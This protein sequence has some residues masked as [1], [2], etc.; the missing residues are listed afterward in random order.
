M[1]NKKFISVVCIILAVIFAATL[2]LG[3]ISSAWAVSQSDIDALKNKQAA[4][5]Q[6][7]TAIQTQIENAKGQVRDAEAQ[8]AELDKKNQLAQQEIDNINEQIALY[9][10][11]IAE[12]AEELKKA[13][14]AEDKQREALEK[15]MR[16]M[17][18]TP[19][20]T[21]VAILFQSSDFSDLLS[22]INDI[23]AIM[24][25]DK[26]LEDKY[27]AA[28]KEVETVKNEYEQT[29]NAQKQTKVELD[30][31]KAD[32][33]A[34]IAQANQV[35]ADLESNI[36]AYKQQ[37]EAEEAREAAIRSQID[38]QVAEFEAQQKA[39]AQ[40]GTGT[41]TNGTGQFTWPVPASRTISSSFGYRVHPIFGTTKYHSGID[42]SASSGS[43]IVAADSGTV[44]TA[45]YSSSYGNYVVIGHGN[46]T[47]TLYA[48]MSKLGCSAG[49]TVT[50]GSTIG[51]V[52]ST[53]WSTGP[54]CHF[55]IRINGSLVNP[56][57]YF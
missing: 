18:E 12:K 2:I 56:A 16:A 52:G 28:R 35:I 9:D 33:E 7:K 34:Q 47:S 32:L 55:E 50:K 38:K 43:T 57:S 54:H 42:I 48:H 21:Y 36:E 24:T 13:Q 14:A 20:L 10:Q 3:A 40:N 6:Q 25:S 29:Q 37:Y 15:R 45:T 22:K 1:R 53:G 30:A 46:G 4:I 5:V 23:S 41:I 49:Q 27:T 19:S 11:L 31:K 26:E 51:Y 39:A 44:L 17:E 8:K